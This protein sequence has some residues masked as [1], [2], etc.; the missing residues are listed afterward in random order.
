MGGRGSI[1]RGLLL[2]RLVG[3]REMG[4]LGRSIMSGGGGRGK[5]GLG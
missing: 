4:I 1:G 2:G 3:S 5:I